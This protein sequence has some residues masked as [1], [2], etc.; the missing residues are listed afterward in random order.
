VDP[1]VRP[2]QVRESGAELEPHLPL[3]E[4]VEQQLAQL[5]E[6]VAGKDVVLL[7]D[8]DHLDVGEG[9]GD[10]AGELQTD[11]TGPDHEDLLAGRH[12]GAQPLETGLRG[13]GA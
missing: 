3:V 12:V 13:R 8:E 4:L 11:G 2:R 10:L 7:L 1:D 9:R 6:V 5:G